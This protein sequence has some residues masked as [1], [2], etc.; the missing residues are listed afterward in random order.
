MAEMTMFACMLDVEKL[1]S[2]DKKCCKLRVHELFKDDD[3]VRQMIIDLGNHL[4]ENYDL[5]KMEKK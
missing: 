4:K 5:H 3:K 2:G 1:N